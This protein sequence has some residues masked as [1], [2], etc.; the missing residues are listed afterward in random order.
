ED[1]YGA[2]RWVQ[3]HEATLNRM[4]ALI[5]V[6]KDDNIA[7]GSPVRYEGQ[8]FTHA[9]KMLAEKINIDNQLTSIKKITKGEK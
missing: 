8:A 4:R 9:A 7:D 1:E 5:N 6:L 2:D 3:Q